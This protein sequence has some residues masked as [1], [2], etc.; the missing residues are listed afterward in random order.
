MKLMDVV[1]RTIPPEPWAE[2][3]KIPWHDPDFSRRMLREHL[4]QQHDAASRRVEIIDRQVA[5]IHHALYGSDLVASSTWAAGL[6]CMPTAS[7]RLGTRP[8]A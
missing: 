4:S 2:G 8:R 5:W 1:R 3:D 7:P 6:A